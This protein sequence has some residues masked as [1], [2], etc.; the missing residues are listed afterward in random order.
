MLQFPQRRGP[1]SFRRTQGMSITP[2]ERVA[3]GTV[4][5]GL[6][7]PQRYYTRPADDHFGTQNCHQFSST[8]FFPQSLS[9]PMK[10]IIT[11]SSQCVTCQFKDTGQKIML[12]KFKRKTIPERNLPINTSH[13]QQSWLNI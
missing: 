9:L 1:V 13:Q 5:W 6:A 7:T 2:R 10:I 3:A 4:S 12:S 11:E 8:F